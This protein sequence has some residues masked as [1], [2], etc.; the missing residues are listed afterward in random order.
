MNWDQISQPGAGEKAK[1]IPILI[2]F[3][4]ASLGV[5]TELLPQNTMPDQLDYLSLCSV[6]H[7][8]TQ[9]LNFAQ[10]MTFKLLKSNLVLTILADFEE[11]LYPLFTCM[12]RTFP[13]LFEIFVLRGN[14]PYT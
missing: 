1:L 3:Y 7:F 9:Q 2:A 4:F 11:I 6:I 14:A 12:G 13:Y 5:P 10:E 8:S